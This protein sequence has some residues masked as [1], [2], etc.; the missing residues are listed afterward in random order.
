MFIEYFDLNHDGKV[1]LDEFKT[2]LKNMRE[3]LH[4]KNGVAKEY[5]S[6]N[7]LVGDRFKH[8]R[9]AKGLE[10]KYKV[11]LTFNQSIGF[12]VEDPRNKELI[13]IERHP[14]VLCD[15]TKYADEMNR[16]GFPM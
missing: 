16:T 3:Q 8:V 13:K 14:I 1:T 10:E 11:P 7:K 4:E 6:Y 12:K 2:A 15:E 9:M 5:K